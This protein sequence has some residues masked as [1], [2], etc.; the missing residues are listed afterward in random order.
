MIEAR[1]ET[2]IAL[3]EL[4]LAGSLAWLMTA[5]EGFRNHPPVKL[6]RASLNRP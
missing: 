1:S 6:I 2:E 5:P 4:S 3:V